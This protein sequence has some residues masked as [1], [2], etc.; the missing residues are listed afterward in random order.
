MGEDEGMGWQSG[1]TWSRPSLALPGH[2]GG[3][4][5]KAR[6]MRRTAESWTAPMA[7][8]LDLD[9]VAS[10]RLRIVC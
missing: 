7:R 6:N 8:S 3:A 2:A 10:L 1:R 4:D 5:A 9:T